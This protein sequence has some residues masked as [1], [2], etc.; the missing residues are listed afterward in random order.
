MNNIL[1]I[2]AHYDDAELGCG[3]TAA[4]LVSQGKKVYKLTL[5]N[6]ETN[7]NQ[8]NIHVDAISSIIQSAKAS[9]IL[10]IREIVE[11]KPIQCCELFYNT[12]IMQRVERIIF[13]LNIDTVFMHYYDD[14]NQDHVEASRI[15]KTASR[16]C[17]NVLMYHSNGYILQQ[18]LN[19]TTF[20]DISDFIDK[21]LS[22]LACYEGDHNR[23]N[24]LFETVIERNHIWG[25]ANKVEY[26]E[27][28]LPLKMLL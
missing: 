11:F 3:G 5:T 8:M 10:G 16:H 22:A 2:G 7:F 12:D 23:F 17:R 1:I 18:Q 13:D 15:C 25:Y 20:I 21:K 6:N 27:G 19:P 26:A 9:A 28:F 24:K 4:K 14:M